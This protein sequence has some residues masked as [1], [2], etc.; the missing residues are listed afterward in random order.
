[1]RSFKKLDP[2]KRHSQITEFLWSYIFH[3]DRGLCQVCG[4]VGHHAHHVKYRSHDRNGHFTNNLILLC[5]KCHAIEHTQS[6]NDVSY[7]IERIS[8]NETKFKESV[9]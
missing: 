3:R 5:I 6:R 9:V 1:M 4:G 8:V 7:Y 2:L